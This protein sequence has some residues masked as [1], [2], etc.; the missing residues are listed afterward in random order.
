MYRDY[1]V[2]DNNLLQEIKKQN[3]EMRKQMESFQVGGRRPTVDNI[4][5]P[6]G[7][8]NMAGYHP[9]NEDTGFEG[10]EEEW[11]DDE[12]DTDT[13]TDE[14][15]NPD[16]DEVSTAANSRD[17]SGHSTPVNKA[18]DSA[19][20]ALSSSLPTSGLLPPTNIPTSG[21]LHN[22]QPPVARLGD[23]P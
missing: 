16:D 3:L 1:N 13:K 6:Y 14:S 11:S 2:I 8:P 21:L 7:Y 5:G 19:L 18:I 20:E 23:P 4:D 12:S 10:D 17:T 15:F 9:D 22:P